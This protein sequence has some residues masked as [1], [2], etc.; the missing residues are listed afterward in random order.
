[1]CPVCLWFL[2][3]PS[4]IRVDNLWDLDLN[5]YVIYLLKKMTKLRSLNTKS[6]EYSQSLPW[7]LTLGLRGE[8]VVLAIFFKKKS[9]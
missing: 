4:T 7:N 8:K 6:S 9:E 3:L 5:G 1:M 2:Y